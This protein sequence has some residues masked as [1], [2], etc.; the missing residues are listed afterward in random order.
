LA[1]PGN[2]VPVFSPEHVL[3]DAATAGLLGEIPPPPPHGS[4]LFN[5]AHWI[6]DKFRTAAVSVLR[7]LSFWHM[8]AMAR[9]VGD[10]GVHS[11]LQRLQAATPARFHLMGHSFGC[12][13][14]TAA[15]CGPSFTGTT[16]KVNSLFLAE[17]AMSLWSF[18]DESQ[19][20]GPS[21]GDGFFRKLVTGNRVAGPVVTTQSQHDLAIGLWYP[22]G[23]SA[24]GQK[25]FIAPEI[26]LPEFGG[27]GH[28]GICGCGVD[29]AIP[30]K[31]AA[32]QYDF[33]A[34]DIYNLD[35]STVI[36]AHSHIAVPEVAHAFWS[37]AISG[38]SA[39]TGD[40]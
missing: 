4:A 2:D 38:F 15:V 28:Y 7:V 25:L 10:A 21:D 40:S 36:T 18:A 17:G 39:V 3:R 9:T 11:L 24:A 26:E 35:G 30:I 34:G 33:S 31:G 32:D 29:Q 37:A 5:P 22:L 14:V 23:A 16:R 1:E 6:G 20:P 12:I 13:V 8:K 27:L 19:I